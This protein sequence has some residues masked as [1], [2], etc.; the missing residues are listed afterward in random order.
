MLTLTVVI[1]PQG[2]QILQLL[3]Q[4]V[5]QAFGVTEALCVRGWQTYFGKLLFNQMGAGKS[6]RVNKEKTTAS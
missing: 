6:R 4:C 1:V 5:S 2:E 3:M